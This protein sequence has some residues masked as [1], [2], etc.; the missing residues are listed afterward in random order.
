MIRTEFRVA[1]LFLANPC[2]MPP[3]SKERDD[4]MI[5]SEQHPRHRQLQSKSCIQR[6]LG[7]FGLAFGWRKIG[8]KSDDLGLNRCARLYTAL[9]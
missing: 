7:R 6:I 9:V 3:E 4:G 1:Q 8:P 5:A 2:W